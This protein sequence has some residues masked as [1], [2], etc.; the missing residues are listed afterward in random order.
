MKYSSTT[1]LI[2]TIVFA[3]LAFGFGFLGIYLGILYT[4]FLWLQ[5]TTPVDAGITGWGLSA[6]LGI[7]GLA[8]F[9]VSAYGLV[10][11]VRSVLKGKD[12][13][14]VRRSFATYVSIG[15]LIALFFLANGLWLYRLTSSNLGFDDLGFVIVVFL[16]A[17]LIAIIV[18]N[19]P[20]VRLY[21]ENEELNKIM[22]VIT[23]P[24]A[25][26]TCAGT[27]VY[28]LSFILLA[29]GSDIYG[30]ANASMELGVG[31]LIM[32]VACALS[33]LAFFGY[34][35]SAKKGEVKKLNG[36]LF[37]AALC[38]LGGGI[39]A[40]G[41]IEYVFQSAR[42]PE[43]ISLVSKS[44]PLAN[45]NYM[46]FAVMSWILGSVLVIASVVFFFSTLTGGKKKAQ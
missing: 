3:L 33:F 13:D 26:F 11:S 21:G 39:L 14:L 19:I 5:S 17:F 32:L 36:F 10:T 41:S 23:G 31:A 6:M 25:A 8:G 40:A 16:I 22:R 34:G 37:E 45:G 43:A 9:V 12:D 42:N 28:G 30:K 46:D 1:R 29:A 2:N 7:F 38:V 27:L 24:L 44:V 15:Y 4:P 20:L 35:R 18:S